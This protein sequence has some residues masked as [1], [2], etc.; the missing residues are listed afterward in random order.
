MRLPPLLFTLISVASTMSVA[1]TVYRWVDENGVVHFSDQPH[2]N[3]EKIQ[4]KAPQTYTPA[5]PPPVDVSSQAQ[6]HQPS[7]TYRSC[8]IASPQSEAAFANTSSV[9]AAVSVQPPLKRGDA[10][11]VMM[12]G[13]PVPGVPPDG[14]AFTISPVDRGSHTLQMQVVDSSGRAIC[15]SPPVT[16]HVH[17]PSVLNPANPAN[18]N[19]PLTP[20]H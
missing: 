4:L 18:P 19:A 14:G 17:Q 15:Q 20:R 3:A 7:Q 12:D 16:F 6:P 10:V 13:Q 9:N 8:T 11:V 5:K 1:A 2:E